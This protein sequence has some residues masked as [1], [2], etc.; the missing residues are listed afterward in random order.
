VIVDDDDHG[1]EAELL[2]GQI[3]VGDDASYRVAI[4]T[5]ADPLLDRPARGR[6]QRRGETRTRTRIA[7][8]PTGLG[9]GSSTSH[10]ARERGIEMSA[11]GQVSK[12]I[13]PCQRIN[14]LIPLA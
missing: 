6:R 7:E 12:R 14:A 11:R 10:G 4:P 2:V 1:G 13:R 9:A 8:L 5:T 3:G